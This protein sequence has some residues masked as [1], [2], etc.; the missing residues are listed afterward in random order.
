V[1]QLGISRVRVPTSVLAV[2]QARVRGHRPQALAAAVIRLD[3]SAHVV[4]GQA[5]GGTLDVPAFAVM[6]RQAER[7]R[8]GPERAG[9]VDEQL[10]DVAVQRGIVQRMPAVAVIPRQSMRGADPD[11]PLPIGP[12][13]DGDR[14]RQAVAR[15][16]RGERR[17]AEIEQVE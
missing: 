12:D 13:R 1:G 4:A 17:C 3:Q 11:D 14:A 15:G 10:L 5:L 16:E 8:A 9:I 2:E 7:V 6:A